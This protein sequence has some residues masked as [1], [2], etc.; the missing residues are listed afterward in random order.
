MDGAGRQRMVGFEWQ[1]MQNPEIVKQY[2]AVFNRLREDFGEKKQRVVGQCMTYLW[3]FVLH[4][5]QAASVSGM[6]EDLSHLNG[7]REGTEYAQRAWA[8]MQSKHGLRGRYLLHVQTMLSKALACVV[9]SLAY[10][11]NPTMRTHGD[12]QHTRVMAARSQV[13]HFDIH[14]HRLL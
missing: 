7:S 13:R 6:Q 1:K 3:N 11:V 5:N 10:V 8:Q 2:K 12:R 14:A 9:T 4:F